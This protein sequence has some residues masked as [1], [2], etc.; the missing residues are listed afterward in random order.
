MPLRVLPGLLLVT[1]SFPDGLGQNPG[2]CEQRGTS[3]RAGDV[4]DPS[5][6]LSWHC[7]GSLG[8]A[9]RGEITRR[10]RRLRRGLGS[11]E[12]H[13]RIRLSRFPPDYGLEETDLACRA[14]LG[15]GP[16]YSAPGV[17]EGGHSRT[18]WGRRVGAR[19]GEAGSPS[20]A[21][22]SGSPSAA[23]SLEIGGG[24]PRPRARW[25]EGPCP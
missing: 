22:S 19:G 9:G 5:R 11:R 18:T 7:C 15:R 13:R 17:T 2:P 12:F 14:S 23:P 24:R 21:W 25:R 10:A 8:V 16:G 1:R 3:K 4:A 20:R 6:G